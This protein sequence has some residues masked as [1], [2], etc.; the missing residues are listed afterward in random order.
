MR[1]FGGN[2][3]PWYKDKSS[4]GLAPV[5][6][7][8]HEHH[9]HTHAAGADHKF[10]DKV[11][12]KLV[13]FNSLPATS[14]TTVAVDNEFAHLNGLSMFHHE[15]IFSPYSHANLIVNEPNTHDEPYGYE[16]GD[17]P[18]DTHGHG[19]LPYLY[20]L[21]GIIGFT[22]TMAFHFR[23]DNRKLSEVF[24]H[25]RLTALQLEDELIAMRR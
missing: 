18:F 2:A 1:R 16:L 23:F 17:D 9:H 8:T 12:K 25:Q 6:T 20:L 15:Y 7:E 13:V 22:T 10:I 24:Y 14:N 4:N 5:Q 19:D 11:D 21:A 3:Q